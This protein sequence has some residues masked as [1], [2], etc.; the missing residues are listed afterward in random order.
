MIFESS[1]TI[2][3]LG[4]NTITHADHGMYMFESGLIDRLEMVQSCTASK[5]LIA[6]VANAPLRS[7]C[8]SHCRSLSMEVAGA[9]SCSEFRVFDDWS[10]VG[11][12][13]LCS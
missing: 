13:S 10:R 12:H 9:G 1:I 11:F 6:M 8:P 3:Y 2:I 7:V 5:E 4:V